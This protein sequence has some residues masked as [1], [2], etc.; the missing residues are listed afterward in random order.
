MN[1]S[2]SKAILSSSVMVLVVLL[3]ACGTAAT[4]TPD[5]TA[6]TAPEPTPT[7]APQETATTPPQS[8]AA[9]QQPAATPVPTTVPQQNP[10]PAEQPE[11][12]KDR[13]TAV[14]G[15][16]PGHLFI[17]QPTDAHTG[18][19]LDTIYAYVGHLDKQ[20]LDLAP[21]SQ[22][23]S[24]EQTAPDE[25]IFNLRPGVTYHNGDQWNAEAFQVYAEFAGDP[26]SGVG[27]YAHTG[28]YTVEVVDELTAR[29]SAERPAPS[30]PGP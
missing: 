29:S 12:A 25:W 6:T 14:I 30:S 15:Q 7:I 8:A 22:V 2:K 23:V 5:P 4:P 28:P 24:W 10:P 27:A 26:A 13:A 16:E 18:Q 20:T 3:V 1:W 19:L 17:M 11:S 21:T 9:A